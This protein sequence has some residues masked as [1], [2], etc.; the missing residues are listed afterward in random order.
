MTQ[1]Q[2][3]S[4]RPKRGFMSNTNET[5]EKWVTELGHV[6]WERLEQLETL[7]IFQAKELEKLKSRLKELEE[8][9]Q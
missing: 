1:P 2:S 9:C 3:F 5:K 8:P 4:Q 7:V 6:N